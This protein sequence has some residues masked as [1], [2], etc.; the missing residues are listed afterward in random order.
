METQQ[1]RPPIGP[2]V[3]ALKESFHPEMRKFPRE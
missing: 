2:A 1:S 3:L